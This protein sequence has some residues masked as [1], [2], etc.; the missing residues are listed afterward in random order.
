VL[1]AS[2]KHPVFFTGFFYIFFL[3]KRYKQM[4]SVL[5]AFNTIP[6]NKLWTNLASIASSI[7][8]SNNNPVAWAASP[9]GQCLVTPGGAVLRDM[10]VNVYLPNLTTPTSAGGCS[11]ILRGVQ[12][13]VSSIGG[14]YGTG[15]NGSAVAGSDTDFYTGYIRL[16][17]QTYGGGGQAPPTPVA[18]IN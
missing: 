15:N 13:V 16:N 18:R 2:T 8:D 6:A 4:T 17:A 1:R 3:Y 11:T 9:A 7:V 5:G 14:Y 10:G 12:L